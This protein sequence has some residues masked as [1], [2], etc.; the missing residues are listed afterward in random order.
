MAK[1]F[2]GTRK[3]TRKSVFRYARSHETFTK[4]EVAR[5]LE[6][7]IPTVTKY[8]NHFVRDGLLRE[9]GTVSVGSEGGRNPMA[10]SLVPQAKVAIGVDVNSSRAKI[11]VID[12]LGQTAYQKRWT[13]PYE[14]SNAYVTQLC[15]EILS[16]ISECGLREEQVL[17]VCIAVP[18]LVNTETETVVYGKVIDNEGMSAADF[19][20]HL[21]YPTHLLHDSAAAGIAVY[22]SGQ[23]PA[24]AF[25]IG[26]GHSIGGSIIVNG[27]IYL[28]D[29]DVAG[30]IGH[31]KV[32]KEGPR[33]YC[34]RV[35]CLDAHCNSRVLTDVAGPEVSDFFE[36][37]DAGNSVAQETWAKYVENLALAVHHVRLL[38]G[39]QVVL[40]GE[41]GHAMVE[42]LDDLYGEV[43]TLAFRKDD[44]QD[45][46][47][48]SDRD[49]DAVA[50]GAGL[51]LVNRF[52]E[53][54][55]MLTVTP[56]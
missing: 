53:D 6:I 48:T 55:A 20:E 38:F 9:E 18:G 32:S 4:V 41:V 46:L 52:Y 25:Y 40:G 51:F 23:L 29:L 35:G 34:G 50:M 47:V 10:Y 14:R 22:S 31:M 54:P 37:L 36:Q 45:F 3:A 19:A 11:F 42:H 56:Y 16:F 43:D 13:V 15:A 1:S 26:L 17:G 44:A 21:P 39:C 5:E 24:N 7:S 33:C 12:L 27:R 30:E 8:L 28:G 2:K 49:A